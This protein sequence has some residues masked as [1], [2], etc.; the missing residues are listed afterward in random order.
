MTPAKPGPT[1]RAPRIHRST[2]RLLL[3]LAAALATPTQAD[4]GRLF[5]TPEQ[6]RE[7]DRPAPVT[8]AAV[9]ADEAPPPPTPP[10]R[11]D[12]FVFTSSGEITVWLDGQPGP[13]PPDLHAAPFP[14]L[15]LLTRHQPPSR[16]R[17]GDSWPPPALARP[18]RAHQARSAAA[19]EVAE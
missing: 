16:L 9:I 13:L 15:E 19:D 6:R 14:A 5:F 10:Q 4:F 3:L 2:H 12:G 8:P 1:A 17:A 18:A 7:L 11:I